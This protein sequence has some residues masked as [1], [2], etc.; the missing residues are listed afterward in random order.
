MNF[1][2]I[3]TMKAMLFPIFCIQSKT[4]SPLTHFNTSNIIFNIQKLGNKI[5]FVKVCKDVLCSSINPLE[6]KEKKYRLLL[7]K[8]PV[9][10][11]KSRNS[12]SVTHEA[13]SLMFKKTLQQFLKEMI[14]I[15]FKLPSVYSVS[16]CIMSAQA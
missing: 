6:Q 4:K 2:I 1:A 8:P 10:G 11:I 7:V 15:Y 9:A 3:V 16:P 12:Y 13:N 5:F 14:S